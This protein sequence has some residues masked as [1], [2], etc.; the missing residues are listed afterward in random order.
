MHGLEKLIESAG[1]GRPRPGGP[2]HSARSPSESI[3]PS[4]FLR[5]TPS[6]SSESILNPSHSIRVANPSESIHPS[7][8]IRVTPPEFHQQGPKGPG[9]L[10]PAVGAWPGSGV[11]GLAGRPESLHPSHSIRVSPS[12]PLPPSR[13]LPAAAEESENGADGPARRPVGSGMGG[14]GGMRVACSRYGTREAIDEAFQ[15]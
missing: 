13:S 6:E 14:G 7:H 12:E 8:S 1:A 3:H 15:L 2:A 4:H 5:V 9:R 11:R 10:G